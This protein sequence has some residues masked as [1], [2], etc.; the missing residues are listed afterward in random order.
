MESGS[1]ERGGGGTGCACVWRGGGLT[2]PS[3]LAVEETTR[4]PH[5]EQ[6]LSPEISGAPHEEQKRAD[7]VLV[8]Y[9]GPWPVSEALVDPSPRSPTALPHL[10]QNWAAGRSDEPQELQNEGGAASGL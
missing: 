4:A 9:S 3:S 7:I 8:T 5:A 2:D 6:K 10:A 1:G